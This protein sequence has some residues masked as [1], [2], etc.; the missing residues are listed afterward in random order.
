MA[1]NERVLAD[2][3][4][5]VDHRQVAVAKTAVKDFQNQFVRTGLKQNSLD[6]LERC[7]CTPRFPDRNVQQGVDAHTQLN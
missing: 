5:V 2:A 1:G 3:P 4:A 7:R 6:L